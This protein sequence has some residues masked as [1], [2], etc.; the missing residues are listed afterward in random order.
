MTAALRQ[1]SSFGQELT[2]QIRSKDE[3][4]LPLIRR[5]V[6]VPLPP[7]APLPAPGGEAR[8]GTR[9]CISAA[10]AAWQGSGL[11]PLCGVTLSL[12][13]ILEREQFH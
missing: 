13:Q 12:D 2:D 3:V 10:A 4:M 5:G 1:E 9:W 7:P 8:L 6:R 11:L